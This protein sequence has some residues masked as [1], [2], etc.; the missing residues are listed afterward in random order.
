MEETPESK[1]VASVKLRVKTFKNPKLRV[2][3]N[4]NENRLETMRRLNNCVDMYEELS[5]VPWNG[6]GYLLVIW[7]PDNPQN[8]VQSYDTTGLDRPNMLPEFIK[9]ILSSPS[10]PF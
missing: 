4:R 8:T 6:C 1:K 10:T 9:A 2:Y 5:G 3:Y 7:D